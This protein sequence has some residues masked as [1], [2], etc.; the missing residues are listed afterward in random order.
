L[1]LNVQKIGKL[2]LNKLKLFFFFKI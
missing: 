1:N 2:N